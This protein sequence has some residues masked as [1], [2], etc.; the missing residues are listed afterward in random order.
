MPEGSLVLDGLTPTIT[1]LINVFKK[2]IIARKFHMQMGGVD[3]PISSMNGV[4][5]SNRTAQMTV[6]CPDGNTYLSTILANS[7]GTFKIKA[8][9]VY[10]DGTT[11]E[12][13]SINFNA[14][15]PSYDRGPYSFSVRLTGTGTFA[16]PGGLFNRRVT[17]EDVHVET[18]QDNGLR[19]YRIPYSADIYPGD[20]IVYNDIETVLGRVTHVVG[21]TG[22][23]LEVTEEDL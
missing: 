14:E 2:E 15:P 9:E 1:I 19:R 11:N 3:V 16:P 5:R 12:Y 13:D 8:T 7:A 18:L 6:V 17:V 21:S 22:M 10:R 4:Y 23:T 20:T